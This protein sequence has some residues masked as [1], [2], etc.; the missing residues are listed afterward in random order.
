MRHSGKSELGPYNEWSESVAGKFLL[1]NCGRQGQ[2]GG[3]W[4]SSACNVQRARNTPSLG[5]REE[6][7]SEGR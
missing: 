5:L 6:A 4:A 3:Q 1:K 7:R 2:D